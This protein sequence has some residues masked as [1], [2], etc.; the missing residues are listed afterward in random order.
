VASGNLQRAIEIYEE[1][2]GRVVAAGPK[3]ESNLIDAADISSLYASMA[4]LYQ[5]SGKADAAA[6]QERRRADLWQ[7][8]ADKLPNNPF[9]LR[10]LSGSGVRSATR[11]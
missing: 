8:W 5:R 11:G 9:V 4:V 7:H 3:P 2:L 6:A 10:Q 1:H